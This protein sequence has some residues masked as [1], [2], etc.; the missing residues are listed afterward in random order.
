[1]SLISGI[2]VIFQLIITLLLFGLDYLSSIISYIDI[3]FSC[4]RSHPLSQQQIDAVDKVLKELDVE[5]IPKLVVWNKVGLS[6]FC[7]TQIQAK[8]T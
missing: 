7:S 1:M 4:N 8:I 3:F 2:N 6:C 5:L